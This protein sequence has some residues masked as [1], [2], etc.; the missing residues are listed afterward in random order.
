MNA[1]QGWPSKSR[2]APPPKEPSTNGQNHTANGRGQ[3]SNRIS[4]KQC[5][6]IMDLLKGAD[7]TKNEID[8][9]KPFE[10]AK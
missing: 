1:D 4:A 6:F 2:R 3:E 7:I 8:A 10:P 9:V 5:R